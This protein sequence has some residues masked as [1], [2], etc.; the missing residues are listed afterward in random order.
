MRFSKA[1]WKQW[2][3]TCLGYLMGEE[4]SLCLWCLLSTVMKRILDILSRKNYNDMVPQ[5][6]TFCNYLHHPLW[7]RTQIVKDFLGFHKFLECLLD[8]SVSVFLFC[9]YIYILLK[10]LLNYFLQEI[11]LSLIIYMENSGSNLNRKVKCI[12]K[13]M[14]LRRSLWDSL[15]SHLR[16][17]ILGLGRYVNWVYYL[18]FFSGMLLSS[19]TSRKMQRQL[20]LSSHRLPK[21]FLLHAENVLLI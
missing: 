6:V 16:N 1:W 5:K 17:N 7:L 9:R 19:I 10:L 14:L 4:G 18:S 15:D 3:S 12:Y 13:C 2:R 8:S 20:C 11:F 21:R